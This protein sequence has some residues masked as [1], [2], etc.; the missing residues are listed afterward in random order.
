MPGRNNQRRVRW[1]NSGCLVCKHLIFCAKMSIQPI[2]HLIIISIMFLF[3]MPLNEQPL[4]RQ[5]Q[6]RS[7]AGCPMFPIL[8]P[9]WSVLA[10]LAW[11]YM[12]RHDIIC[13]IR[14]PI[15]D[16]IC[17]LIQL[18]IAHSSSKPPLS[19]FIAHH[20]PTGQK[21]STAYGCAS[22]KWS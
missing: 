3:R 20:C 16:G 7:Y 15:S 11:R 12:L 13:F 9:A 8:N 5:C 1:Q 2:L 18:G 4:V 6:F 14:T 21:A 19:Q 17:R 10:V 22:L